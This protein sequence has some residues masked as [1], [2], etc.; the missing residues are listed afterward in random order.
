VISDCSK[1]VGYKQYI[2][3]KILPIYMSNR[4]VIFE[5]TGDNMYILAHSTGNKILR[6]KSNKIHRKSM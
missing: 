3:F 5:I 6:Y 2:E 1:D 4:L